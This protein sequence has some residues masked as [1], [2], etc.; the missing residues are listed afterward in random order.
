LVKKIGFKDFYLNRI[1][2]R[3]ISGALL[4]NIFDFSKKTFLNPTFVL[5][6]IKIRLT[7]TPKNVKKSNKSSSESAQNRFLDDILANNP[8]TK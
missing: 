5:H 7:E 8:G 3:D 4:P 2:L 1:F 6:S